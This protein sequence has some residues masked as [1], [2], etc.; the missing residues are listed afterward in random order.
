MVTGLTADP[1]NTPFVDA[2]V[3]ILITPTPV[4]EPPTPISIFPVV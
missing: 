1:T 2:P 4:L 3:P